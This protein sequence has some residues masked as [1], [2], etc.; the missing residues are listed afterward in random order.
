MYV[1]DFVITAL[2]VYVD[3]FIIDGIVHFV[4]IV[5]QFEGKKKVF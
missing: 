4:L 5:H 3:D 2:F 1:D